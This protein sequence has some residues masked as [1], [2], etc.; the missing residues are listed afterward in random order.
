MFLTVKRKFILSVMF[1]IT[2]QLAAQNINVTFSFSNPCVGSDVQFNDLT[3][4]DFPI[5]EWE[6][7]FDYF[8]NPGVYTSTNNNPTFQFESELKNHV[9]VLRVKDAMGNIDSN[10]R[11]VRPNPSPSIS[12]DYKSFCFPD[13]VEF[14]DNSTINGG[15]ISSRQWRS[16]GL[17]IGTAKNF[18]HLF[19]Q[20]DDYKVQYRAVSAAGCVGIDS[21]FVTYTEEPVLSYN[22]SKTISYCEGDSSL[23]T[24]SG[25]DSIIWDF[26]SDQLSNYFSESGFFPFTAFKTEHCFVRDSIE[27]IFAPKPNADAGMDERISI[28]QSVTLQGS[29]G[30][31]YKWLPADFLSDPNS[32]NP[33]ASPK[34]TITY[35]VIV[36]NDD[37]CT[38]SAQV[39]VEVD[40]DADFDIPNLITP[41]GDGFNDVWD[42]SIIPEIQNA[43][44]TVFNRYGWEV[45][46]SNNYNNNWGGTFNGE[47]L[48]DGVYV[49]II[50]FANEDRR[51]IKGLLNIMRN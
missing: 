47:I 34:E 6:W 7:D 21:I 15:T 16:N 27:S 49:F 20:P 40:F 17:L 46:K 43:Q 23:L 8:E 5:V 28:G 29:G 2:I 13:G 36:T 31:T 32:S 22:P 33:V 9:I 50:D 3:T 11:V 24:V 25:V 51:L 18:T 45:F 1:L 37:G 48:P 12:L 44:I 42:L 14:I 4:S 19:Q 26:G 10:F 39:T 41:N 35:T 30:T 38:D